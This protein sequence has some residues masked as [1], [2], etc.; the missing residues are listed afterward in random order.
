MKARVEQGLEKNLDGREG[1]LQTQ[2]QQLKIL[3]VYSIHRSEERFIRKEL[4]ILILT[5]Y[6]FFKAFHFG[7]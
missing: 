7:T 5:S 4:I 6:N 3:Q 1:Q 2:E